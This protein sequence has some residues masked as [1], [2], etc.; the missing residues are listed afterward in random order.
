MFAGVV[1][2]SAA[3]AFFPA[4]SQASPGGAPPPLV[5][6]PRLKPGAVIGL[7]APGG[8]VDDAI[9]Q[10][11]VANLEGQGFTVKAGRNLRAAHGG[12]AGAVR[13]RLEDLHAMFADREVA[14]I[15]AAR[16]GSGSLALL[17]GIDYR[18]VRRRP[19]ILV[20]F[21]D[22]TALHLAL[23][24]H[25]GLV[26]F[27]GPV[28]S[29]TFSEFSVSHM[30]G[31][32]MEPSARR[33]LPI[34]SENEGRAEQSPQL[35]ARV[36]REGKAEGRLVG[37]NL[38]MLCAL[39]GTPYAPAFA[40]SLL[41][42]EE[43]GEAPYRIDRMLTQLRLARITTQAQAV[44]MGVFQRCEAN[45][46][47]PSLSLAQTLDER[48]AELRIPSAYGYSFGHIAHQVTIPV[49]VKARFDTEARTV[50]LLEAA[51]SD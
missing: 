45:D 25:A 22:V 32:L 47:E 40:G 13:E 44:V 48:M 29:S 21:S 18:L 12:Y 20:G 19:K 3:A 24:R 4:A 41:F 42:L 10:K 38:S 30:L 46:G 28:A 15:W 11:C 9:I 36:F 14:A 34:A 23:L 39:L 43:V 16:G 17:P 33:V 6:P 5:R 2:A 31:V 7:V 37:G 51:V 26:T 49:G 50:T 8:V 27:H 1:A 35:K